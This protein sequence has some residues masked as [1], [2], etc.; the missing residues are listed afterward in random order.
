MIIY[1][2]PS[3]THVTLDT[4]INEYNISSDQLNSE[5]EESDV[6]FLAAYFDNVE[7]YVKVLGLTKGEQ[8]DVKRMAH[9]QGNQV[10]MTECLSLWRQHNPSTAILR[11]LLDILLKLRKEEVASNISGYY[12]PKPKEQ[13]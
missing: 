5:V 12:Y 3:D 4:L 2:T 9:S 8:V 13:S 1:F 7:L 10:A 6:T 11:T